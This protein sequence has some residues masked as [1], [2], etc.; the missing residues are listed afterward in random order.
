[1]LT[2]ERVTAARNSVLAHRSLAS[3]VTL[4]RIEAL[5]N[6]AHVTEFFDERDELFLEHI[7]HGVPQCSHSINLTINSAKQ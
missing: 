7:E 2:L 6:A 4:Q 3:D 5:F 1:M